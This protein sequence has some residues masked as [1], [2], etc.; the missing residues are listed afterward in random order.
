MAPVARDILLEFSRYV[1]EGMIPNRFPD[2][3][4]PPEY[5]TVDATLWYFEAIR[6]YLAATGDR[7]FVTRRLLRTLAEIIDHHAA[8]TRYGIRV[9]PDGLLECGEQLTWMDARVD[10]RAITPRNG[11]P[12]EVQALWYN[13]LCVMRDL[14]PAGPYGEMAAKAKASFAPLFWNEGAG[15][16]D[17]V[18]GD[19]SIR[20]NQLAAIGLTHK[21]F[22]DPAR[23]RSIL[24]VVERELLTPYGLRTLSPGDSRYQG[25]YTSDAA[26]HQGTVWPWL[27]GLFVAAHLDAHA[28]SPE[29][30]ARARAWL[31]PLDAYRGGPGLGHICEIFDGDTPHEPRG[32]IAQ[33]WSLAE[34]L[35]ATSLAK[36]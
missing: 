31:A 9:A 14:E 6:A 19:S 11:K 1:S 16:L 22:D 21:I 8:G 33:A 24:G 27:M 2:R 25:R 13:A 15:C 28:H 34:F 7:D 3:N 26:Y 4:E 18:A 30:K 29:A 20:P 10:G 36:E 35:R 5:N 23:T 17:D 12:A 32:A